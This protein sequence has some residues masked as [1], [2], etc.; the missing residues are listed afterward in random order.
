MTKVRMRDTTSLGSGPL[1]AG[2]VYDLADADAEHLKAVGLA[3][4]AQADTETYFEKQARE[5]SA[6]NVDNDEDAPLNP[7]IARQVREAGTKEGDR[8]SAGAAVQREP[9]NAPTN[10]P[11][12]AR[13]R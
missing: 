6:E 1:L 9:L 12:N 3:R 10:A 2:E 4:A 11:R 13:G 8:P 7:E 5:N